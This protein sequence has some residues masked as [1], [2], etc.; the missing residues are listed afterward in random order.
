MQY[1]STIKTPHSVKAL[2]FGYD[3]C[4]PHGHSS[5][6]QWGNKQQHRRCSQAARRTHS[7]PACM[8]AFPQMISL[9]TV[10]RHSGI[11]RVCIRDFLS[12]CK[13]IKVSPPVYNLLG[14]TKHRALGNMFSKVCSD[15]A[16]VPKAVGSKRMIECC[17][18][19]FVHRHQYVY[20]YIILN[21]HA[22]VSVESYFL[23]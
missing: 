7:L 22:A 15:H 17:N 9:P 6:A 2:G 11:T 3:S 21:F 18:L 8:T 5:Q 19:A 12:A 14:G 10:A 23:Y 16:V 13:P 4:R 1:K 20:M